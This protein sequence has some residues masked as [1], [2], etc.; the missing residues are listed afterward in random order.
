MSSYTNVRIPE[1]YDTVHTLMEKVKH[2]ELDKKILIEQREHLEGILNNIPRAIREWGY[3]D[4]YFDMDK[5]ITLIEKPTT[6]ET[7]EGE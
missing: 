7:V 1:Y 3:V 6:K 2:L 4:I 5:K